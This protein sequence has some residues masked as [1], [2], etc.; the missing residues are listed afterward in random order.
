MGVEGS[1]EILL[2]AHLVPYFAL[3]S[4]GENPSLQENLNKLDY[5]QFC[6]TVLVDT[7]GR[8][9][10]PLPEEQFYDREIID[11]EKGELEP[12]DAETLVSQADKFYL[13]GGRPEICMS[14][15]YRSLIEASRTYDQDIEFDMLTPYCFTGPGED[16]LE[17]KLTDDEV[18][19]ELLSGLLS[20]YDFEHTSLISNEKEVEVIDSYL[21]DIQ[22]MYRAQEILNREDYEASFRTDSERFQNYGSEQIHFNLDGIHLP[23]G[24]IT[25]VEHYSGVNNIFENLIE[26]DA[27]YLLELRDPGRNFE[28]E[29]SRESGVFNLNSREKSAE[30]E[31]IRE[32]LVEKARIPLQN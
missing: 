30:L 11:I 14:N 6:E 32:L 21:R 10:E 13:I 29:L 25:G 28:A 19:V 18:D 26:F 5:R 12:E 17:D 22:R 31:E 23:S 15:S 4:A 24:N 2:A 8:T 27:D 7:A 9:G 16:T 3:D 1:Y 20:S